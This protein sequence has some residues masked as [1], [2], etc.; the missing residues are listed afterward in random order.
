MST[1]PSLT[2]NAKHSL[3]KR[4]MREIAL[5]VFGILVLMLVVSIYASSH[6]MEAEFNQRYMSIVNVISGEVEK[7]LKTEEIYA[8]NVK[9]EMEYRLNS[10]DS[11]ISALK[12][13]L[14]LN[15]ISGGYFVAFEPDRLL[16]LGKE[17]SP[18]IYK[19]GGQ[20][21]TT[22]LSTILPDYLNS[23]WYI[24]AKKEGKGFWADPYVFQ[25]KPK[26]C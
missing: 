14:G 4:L 8:L 23:D 12:E 2:N 11:I 19:S 21:F 9:D 25:D 10:P 26:S 22:D 7:V 24:R 6:S 17:Y 16:Q 20:T 5:F 1:K 15:T 13:E 3:G 18:F